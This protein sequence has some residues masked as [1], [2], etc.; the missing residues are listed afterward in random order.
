VSPD[1]KPSAK[2]IGLRVGRQLDALVGEDLRAVGEHPLHPAL[3]RGWNMIDAAS[4]LSLA[5]K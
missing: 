2:R 5:Q 3:E 1:S 4:V